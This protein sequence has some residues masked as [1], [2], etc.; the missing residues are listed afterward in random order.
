MTTYSITRRY[1]NKATP[2]EVLMEGLTLE[3]AQE[4]CSNPETSSETC[5]KPH[6][7]A[8]TEQCG[9]WFDSYNKE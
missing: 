3:E 6:N 2:N 8:R 1:F 7:V 9:P 4:H 5:T